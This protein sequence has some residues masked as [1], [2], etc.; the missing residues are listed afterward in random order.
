MRTIPEWDLIR[1]QLA[2]AP[3]PTNLQLR[4]FANRQRMEPHN[5]DLCPLCQ[6][7]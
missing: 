7:T 3:A 4:L 2:A 5:Y 6:D 1:A